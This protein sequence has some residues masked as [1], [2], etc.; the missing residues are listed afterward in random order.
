MSAGT[1]HGPCGASQVG[2]LLL[3]PQMRW[4]CEKRTP[5]P[6][7]VCLNSELTRLCSEK[8]K[9]DTVGAAAAENS[10]WPQRAR[11]QM[12]PGPALSQEVLISREMAQSKY[13]FSFSVRRRPQ[14]A[15]GTSR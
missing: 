6:G 2:A 14:S 9:S 7:G 3:G 1:R 15:G 13:G 11:R 8:D 12:L 4:G 5:A 10:K